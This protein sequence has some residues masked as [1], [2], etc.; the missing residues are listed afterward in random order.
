MVKFLP[1]ST[2]NRAVLMVEPS[3]DL[4]S[5]MN[6]RNVGSHRTVTTRKSHISFITTGRRY[7]AG[8]ASHLHE[9][10][11]LFWS[12]NDGLHPCFTIVVQIPPAWSPQLYLAAVYAT[13]VVHSKLCIFQMENP[14][15]HEGGPAII[16]TVNNVAVSYF[17]ERSI[18][19]LR[20]QL[21]MGLLIVVGGT[22]TTLS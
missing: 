3:V 5:T 19:M 13:I 12:I 7:N 18:D 4:L 11:I 1:R 8:I 6:G 20:F 21:C 16:T 22:Q 17:K 9:I 10:E 2:R 14:L 15:M